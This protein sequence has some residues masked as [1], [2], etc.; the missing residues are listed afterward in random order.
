VSTPG[1]SR[2]F[3]RRRRNEAFL[4]VALPLLGL[5]LGAWAV[6]RQRH[7][8]APPPAVEQ[9]AEPAAPVAQPAPAAEPKMPAESVGDHL[10]PPANPTAPSGLNPAPA[11]PS[12]PT[13]PAAPASANF[14]SGLGGSSP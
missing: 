6:Y 2:Y 13:T 8:P 14:G 11:A 4:V 12:T 1:K 3:A 10:P 7:R 5:I 9:P